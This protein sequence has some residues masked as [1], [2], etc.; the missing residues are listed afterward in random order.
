MLHQ[1]IRTGVYGM[2][3]E[4]LPV[5]NAAGKGKSNCEYGNS[6]GDALDAENP[7][8]GQWIVST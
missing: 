7:P 6:D 5:K 3:Q 4:N 1:L 2:R 8:T